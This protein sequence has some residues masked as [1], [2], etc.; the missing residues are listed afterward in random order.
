MQRIIDELR[1]IHDRLDTVLDG[2]DSEI[3]D[4]VGDRLPKPIAEQLENLRDAI[5][6]LWSLIP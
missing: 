5:V 3:R 4:V 2:L 1:E 6:D